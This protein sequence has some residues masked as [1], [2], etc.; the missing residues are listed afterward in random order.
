LHTSFRVGHSTIVKFVPEVC[1]AIWAALS[2]RKYITDIRDC[3]FAKIANDFE[4]RWNLPNCVGAI[5][6]K[7]IR[8]KA[9]PKSGSK[10]INHKGYFSINLFAICDAEY[11]FMYT[12][13]G[14]FGSQNDAGI[15]HSS[16]FSSLLENNRLG[17]K[18]LYSTFLIALMFVFL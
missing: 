13:I 9:P 14:S 11:K 1:D 16:V 6:G 8:I 15:Y 7:H 17:K 10:Y 5:D 4:N 3:D 2:T 12:E 18:K